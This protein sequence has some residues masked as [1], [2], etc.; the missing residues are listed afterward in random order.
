MAAPARVAAYEALRAVHRGQQDLPAALARSRHRLHDDRDKALAAEIV[1]GTLRWRGTLDFLVRAFANRPLEHLDPEV[2]DIL[3]LSAYQLLHLDRVPAS[4][5]VDDGVS[6]VRFAHRS[7]AGGFVNAVLRSLARARHH[8]PWPERPPDGAPLEDVAAY[9]SI[10]GSHPAWLVARWVA[11]H[12]FE[13]TEAWCRFDNE[14]APLTLRANR[15]RLSRD[16]LRE[17]LRRRGVETVPTAY[18]PDG[19][20]ISSGHPLAGHAARSGDFIVQDEV[21]QVISALVGA[22]PG[23]VVLDLCAAPGGKTTAVAGAMENRGLLVA[24]DLRAR[25]MRLLRDTVRSTGAHAALVQVDGRHDLP[26]GAIFDRVLVDAPCSG[27][28]TVRRDPD[29]KWR[30]REEDL[31]ALADAQQR[32]LARAAA[33]VR[34]GGLL[35]YSTCSSEPEENEHVVDAFLAG[36]PEFAPCDV[37]HALPDGSPI[38]ALIDDAGHLRTWPYRDRLEAFFAAVLVRR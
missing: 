32:L 17:Q 26:F 33:V 35:V 7:S 1:T 27:L 6:L 18:A 29:I 28:G 23:D 38:A 31:P 22:R 30:R 5:A 8:L 12:G 24:S 2:L 20:V 15:L 16:E 37:R 10:V 9:L 11:R 19:L 13:A 4:A 36:Q 34:S 25:R 3:R 21:S 14:P